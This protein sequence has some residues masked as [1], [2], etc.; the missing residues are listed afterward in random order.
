LPAPNGGADVCPQKSPLGDFCQL[1]KVPQ[2]HVLSFSIPGAASS[3][4]EH[5]RPPSTLGSLAAPPV[6]A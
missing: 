2:S 6:T 3:R 5:D 4:A 1:T